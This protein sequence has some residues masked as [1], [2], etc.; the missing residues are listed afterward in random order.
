MIVPGPDILQANLAPEGLDVDFYGVDVRPPPAAEGETPL[1][2]PPQPITLKIAI[3]RPPG[4]L[5][6]L[7]VTLHDARR[8]AIRTDVSTAPL[9]YQVT[10]KEYGRYLLK[11]EAAKPELPWV[12]DTRY[13]LN[14]ERE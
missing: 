12:G 3:P 14:V 10:V 2:V 4:Q 11:V 9:Q 1:T 7:K 13:G 8:Q 5:F 6:P